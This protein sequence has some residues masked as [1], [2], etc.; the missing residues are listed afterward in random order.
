MI[1]CIPNI[2][3]GYNYCNYFGGV[4]NHQ[5]HDCL[6]NRLFMRRSKKTPKLRVIG[7]CEGNSSVT[8]EF[9]AQRTSNAESVSIWLRHHGRTVLITHLQ[10][11]LRKAWS[12]LPSQYRCTST[13]HGRPENRTSSFRHYGYL[14][15][16]LHIFSN[17]HQPTQHRRRQVALLVQ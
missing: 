12:M 7:L 14:L 3:Y 4:I 13:D 11:P 17:G 5:S 15:I 9:P 8:G 10:Q 16:S 1:N 6:L 2:N